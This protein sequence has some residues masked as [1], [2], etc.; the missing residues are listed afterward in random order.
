MRSELQL[1]PDGPWRRARSHHT[2][3][4]LRRLLDGRASRA[5]PGVREQESE[6][7]ARL[8]DCCGAAK[9]ASEYSRAAPVMLFSPRPTARLPTFHL[10]FARLI[11]AVCVASSLFARLDAPFLV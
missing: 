10:D 6:Q 11:Y 9:G 1:Q 5:L 7:L 8:V 4:P 3:A 2:A